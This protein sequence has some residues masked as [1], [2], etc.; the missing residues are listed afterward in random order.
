MLVKAAPCVDIHRAKWGEMVPQGISTFIP[1]S[2]A[3]K[4]ALAIPIF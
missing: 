3:S 2:S 4:A 1:S